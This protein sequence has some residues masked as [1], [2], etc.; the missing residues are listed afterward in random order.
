MPR[1]QRA[2]IY[3]R[4]SRADQDLR[5]QQDETT[6]LVRRRGWVFHREFSDHGISG[7]HD[8]RPGFREM[9]EAARAKRFNVLVVYRSD[10]LFRSLRELIV[11]LDELTALGCQFVSVNEPF[12]TT[13]PSGT[14]LLQMVGAFAQFERGVLIE[15]TKSGLEAARRRGVRLGR[16]RIDVDIRKAIQLRASGLSFRDV[17]RALG[18]KLATLHRAMK[19]Q[20]APA[21]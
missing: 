11:T 7:S 1:E 21:N 16:P 6:E 9:M 5:M 19:A 18:V 15:R 17:A 12:D 20:R 2:A 8:R 13:T 4:V 3:V 14:L 10:R